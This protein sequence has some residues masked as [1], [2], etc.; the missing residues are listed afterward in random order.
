MSLR[1][2]CSRSAPESGPHFCGI[3]PK[4]DHP[5][6]YDFRVNGRRHRSSTD[7]ADKHQARDIEARE[8]ARIL[9]GRHGIRRQPDIT[10]REF[11][12]TY[13]RDYAHP[14]K[15]S[16][17]RDVEIVKV[18]NRA[19]GLVLLHEVTAHRI[20]QFKRERLAGKWRSHGY[21]GP[22]KSI[23][24]GTVNR[25]LDTLRGIFSKAVEWRKLHEHPMGAV[26]RFKVDNRRTRI[27]TEA[28]QL[29][30]LAACPAKLGRMVRLALITG[31]RIG[32]LL[33]LTWADIGDDELTFV[34][35]K[36]GRSRRLPLSAAVRAVL[37]S[38]PRRPGHDGV[39]FLNARTGKPYTVNGVAHVFRRALTRAGITSGDVTLHT[40][41]HTALSRMIATGIDQFTVMA[42]SGHS[43]TRMLERYTHPTDAR[44]LEALTLGGHVLV[45]MDSAAAEAA[46]ESAD[47]LR[48]FGG[49]REAR[50]RDL[51]VANAAL[52]QL[53]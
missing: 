20:E 31:A 24:P 34:E 37:V 39:V 1:K 36:N 18:L 16:V 11:A 2:R 8:R 6:H 35:T 42:I 44:K 52:S 7:T 25:E 10:F 28:E 4:C 45:T 14:N 49:R 12:A 5:W 40:L 22:A 3:S 13:L 15:R 50:T 43:S 48:K 27:L 38:C 21:T 30:L 23:Q 47:L 32:E 17:G 46:A 53:S 9:D 51:R 33:A 41:R 19:F 26:R 29:A